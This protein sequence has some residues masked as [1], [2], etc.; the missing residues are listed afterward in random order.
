MIIN[1]A[2]TKV[3]MASICHVHL[4]KALMIKILRAVLYIRL[5]PFI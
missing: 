5:M 1:N 4:G 2:E 3:D